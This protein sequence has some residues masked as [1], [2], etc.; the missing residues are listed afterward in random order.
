MTAVQLRSEERKFDLVCYCKQKN[1]K[2][3]QRQG[4]N[5]KTVQRQSTNVKTVQRQFRKEFHIYPQ[6][7]F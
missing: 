3:V 2:T 4:T 6:V 1:V 5:I 7:L